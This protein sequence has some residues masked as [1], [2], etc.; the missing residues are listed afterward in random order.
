MQVPNINIFNNSKIKI[1]KIPAFWESYSFWIITLIIVLIIL[2]EWGFFFISLN[3]IESSK[4][5]IQNQGITINQ[6]GLTLL[7]D[8]KKQREQG[9]ASINS[10]AL[11]NPFFSVNQP[12]NNVDKGSGVK[13]D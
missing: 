6:D 9:F 8:S 3:K 7:R 10:K 11:V 5:I 4:K 2:G 12:I 13:T 1:S